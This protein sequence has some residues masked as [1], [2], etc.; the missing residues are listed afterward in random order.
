V[1][2]L[3]L[4]TAF[5]AAASAQ[6]AEQDF[7]PTAM[8]EEWLK[9]PPLP[10][11]TQ[12]KRFSENGT[13]YLVAA[14]P[15]VMTPAAAEAELDLLLVRLVQQWIEE[16]FSAEAAEHVTVTPQMIRSQWVPN[17]LENPCVFQLPGSTESIPMYRSFAQVAM[18]EQAAALIGQRW[19][20]MQSELRE[21]RQ[22]GKLIRWSIVGGAFLCLLATVHSYLRMDYL[23]RGYQTGRLRWLLA[24]TSAGIV[25]LAMWLLKVVH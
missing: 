1:A 17:H 2:V 4:A 25:G 8:Q 21:L 6:N 22:R 3:L 20:A 15:P 13:D 5:C 19:E 23:T 18:T 10:D 11:W 14:T 16:R 12:K 24:L 9:S 7:G